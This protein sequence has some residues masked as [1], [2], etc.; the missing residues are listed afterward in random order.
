MTTIYV[1]R[2]GAWIVDCDECSFTDAFDAEA[3]A[4][5]AREAHA[6]IHTDIDGQEVMFR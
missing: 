3:D 6:R 2:G 5:D 4:I 1:E